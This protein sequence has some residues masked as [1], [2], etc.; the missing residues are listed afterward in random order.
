VREKYEWFVGDNHDEILLL[1]LSKLKSTELCKRLLNNKMKYAE[2]CFSDDL[3]EKK[4]I[5]LS[6]AID[7]ALNYYTVPTNSL[8]TKILLRY[9]SLL[10]FTIAEEVA[11]LNN[12]NGLRDVQK[13]TEDGHGLATLNKH[14]EKNNFS[15]NYFCYIVQ[16]GHFYEYL[17]YK[18]VHDID[19]VSLGGKIK[20]DEKFEENKDKLFT[21]TDLFRRVPELYNIIDEY[22]GVPP[23]SLNIGHSNKNHE[24]EEKRRQEYQNK[25]GEFFILSAP[26]SSDPEKITFVDIYP[27]TNEIDLNFYKTLNTPFSEFEIVE[28]ERNKTKKIVCQFKH[29]NTGIWWNHLST[30]KSNYCPTLHI[31]PLF[32]KVNDVLLVHYM[33][34]YT[35]SIIVRYLPDVWYRITIGNLN[36]FG[37]LIE[38]YLAIFDH[39][40]LK[41]VYERITENKI[42][43]STPGGLDSP[44]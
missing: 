14:D 25:T 24:I 10:Q 6:S 15:D 7:S 26:P 29:I 9:Y 8:N 17:K 1:R 38:H 20:K 42:H 34:L 18:N 12:T 21:I 23:L 27:S 40:I 41:L 28:N 43:L 16:R 3:I 37:S 44:I 19:Q 32:G 36:H 30:Y 31:I 5:G 39:I 13:N 11:S 4:A 35:L 22:F 2:E 33:L